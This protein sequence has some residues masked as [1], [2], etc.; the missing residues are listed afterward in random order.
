MLDELRTRSAVLTLKVRSNWIPHF[1]LKSILMRSCKVGIQFPQW[2]Q[3]QKKV[4]ELD[5]SNTSISG[6]LPKWLHDMPLLAL[7]LSHNHSSGPI[8]KLPSTINMV[9]LFHNYIS[10]L[11]RQNIG[12]MMPTLESFLLADNLINGLIPN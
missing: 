11:L 6:T 1:R 8:L 9:D 12:D 10:R 7:Y 2:L 3:R 4:V 5:L